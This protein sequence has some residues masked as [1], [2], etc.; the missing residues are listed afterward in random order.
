MPVKLSQ[1]RTARALKL[2]VAARARI[3][4]CRAW[5]I[6][7]ALGYAVHDYEDAEL[8]QA[9]RQKVMAAIYPAGTFDEWAYRKTNQHLAN[10]QARALRLR[11]LDSWIAAHREELK[12]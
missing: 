6:C 4:D 1:R 5:S 7:Y 8:V 2:L 12:R 10:D 3:A 11:W 9:M